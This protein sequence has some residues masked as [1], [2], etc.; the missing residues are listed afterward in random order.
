[1]HFEDDV[2]ACTAFLDW[3]VQCEYNG[4]SPLQ[5]NAT[6]MGIAQGRGG[7]GIIYV[8]AA[9]NSYS[10]GSDVNFEGALNSRY[11]ISVGAV[12]K[13]GL[14]ASYSI[15]GA[16]LFVSA[17]GGDLDSYTNNIVALAGGGCTDGGAG[18]SFAAPVVSGLIAL[19]L[20]ANPELFWRDVQGILALTSRQVEANDTASWTIN[21]AG[22]HHSYLYGFGLVDANAS[23]TTAQNWVNFP[24]EIQLLAESGAVD[25]KIPDFS[26]T[27]STPATSTVTVNASSTFVTESVIVYLDLTHSSRGDVEVVLTSP[28]GTASILAPGQR[29]ENS[30]TLERWKLMTVRNWGEPADGVWTLSLIDQSQGD[31]DVCVDLPDWSKAIGETQ[32]DCAIMETLQVCQGG[33]EGPGFSIFSGVTTGIDDVFFTDENGIAM[34]DACCVC[35]GGAVASTVSDVLRS[36]RIAVYGH[37]SA[38]PSA[39]LSPGATAPIP[40]LPLL[41]TSP[42]APSIIEVAPSILQQPQIYT[43]TLI[44]PVIQQGPAV[45]SPQAGTQPI[46]TDP[47]EPSSSSSKILLMNW[48]L[49]A[50]VLLFI[51]SYR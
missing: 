16:P 5:L 33:V 24:P 49:Y 50:I 36:W 1:M 17:P 15:G 20:Q 6:M 32:F 30:Q 34:T 18:T 27:G 42:M 23:V 21:A 26:T 25:L 47:R 44:A 45:L 46:R 14:H 2:S 10:A 3:G 28:S 51:S 29:P 22:F 38:T 35:G 19:I 4:Q 13:D 9:G 48:V 7:K 12:G 31:L 41:T 40:T 8:Y 37:N 43:P 39:T 11:T